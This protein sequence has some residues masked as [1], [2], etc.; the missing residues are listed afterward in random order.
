MREWGPI[1]V[2]KMKGKYNSHSE[3]SVLTILLE[4]HVPI[5]KFQWEKDAALYNENALQ[6]NQ[7]TRNLDSLRRTF[8]TCANKAKPKG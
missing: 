6:M 4:E 7:N 3:I 2:L 8:N 1:R 5:G